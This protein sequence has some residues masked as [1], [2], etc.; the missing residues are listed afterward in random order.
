MTV[1]GGDCEGNGVVAIVKVAVW[2]V[3]GERVGGEMGKILSPALMR[4]TVP[5]R[6]VI[7]VH[8]RFQFEEYMLRMNTLKKKNAEMV[9][10][11]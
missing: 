9:G 7:H 11:Q 4:Q 8:H 10:Y 1:C 5:L 2:V 6:L 3:F